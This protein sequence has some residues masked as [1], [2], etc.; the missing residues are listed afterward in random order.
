MCGSED[1]Q[2]SCGHA[3]DQAK[4]PCDNRLDIIIADWKGKPGALIPVL[5][6]AQ[7]QFGYLSSA[8]L[9][10]ISEE[11]GEPYNK[12]FGVV[13]FYSFFSRVPR[14]KY[15]VRVCMGTACYIR[16][17]QQVLESFE[18]RLAIKVGQTT[19]DRMFTL[20][21][22]RC[23]GACGLAPAVSINDKVYKNVASTRVKT[24]VDS[25]YNSAKAESKEVAA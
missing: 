11:L 2:C 20:E 3:G 7:R 13:T 25:Y 5:Q 14:G 16:G 18:T 22:A 21:V 24:I 10:R 19:E 15:L 12:V 6:E 23:F 4:D 8:S 17:A 1:G 9:Q